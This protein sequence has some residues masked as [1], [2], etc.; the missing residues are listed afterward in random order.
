M[1]RW[2]DIWCMQIPSGEQAIQTAMIRPGLIDRLRLQS[3]VKS[4]EAFARLIGVSRPTLQRLRAGE[5]P[6]LRSVI[7]IA[8]A[9][10]LGLGEVV[11][12]IE[13]AE[14]EA[15]EKALAS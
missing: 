8:T 12:V 10:G 2:G 13:A 15:G 14:S 7:G 9:F 11:Q 3:G 6:T 5:E 1:E 4:D